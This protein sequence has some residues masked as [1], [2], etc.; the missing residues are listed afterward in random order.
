VA[1]EAHEFA[2]LVAANEA[3][4]RLAADLGIPDEYGLGELEVCALPAPTIAG[5]QVDR[6]GP[7]DRGS[8]LVL[9]A[10]SGDIP[11][12]ELLEIKA[13]L[14]RAVGHPE[15]GLVV[16]GGDVAG[17]EVLDGR[18]L[19]ELG[20][21]FVGTPGCCPSCGSD[22]VVVHADRIPARQCARC[23]HSWTEYHSGRSV[24]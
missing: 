17:I 23:G 9:R 8:V 2:T 16:A 14:A 4:D 24:A 18:A 12:P 3:R 10:A 20:W 15:F 13:A 6:L 1:W 22:E 7:I 5:H 21:V 19:A 11:R